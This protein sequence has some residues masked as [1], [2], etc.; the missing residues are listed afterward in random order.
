MSQVQQSHSTASCHASVGRRWHQPCFTIGSFDPDAIDTRNQRS[1]GCRS[2]TRCSPSGN[3]ND[4]SNGELA[5]EFLSDIVEVS[6]LQ[7]GSHQFSDSRTFLHER[8]ILADEVSADQFQVRWTLPWFRLA[9]RMK[10]FPSNVSVT[11]LNRRQ[12]DK[13]LSPDLNKVGND[14]LPVTHSF[15]HSLK[16]WENSQEHLRTQLFRNQVQHRIVDSTDKYF[17]FRRPELLESLIKDSIH[18]WRE[19]K[20]LAWTVFDQ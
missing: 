10:A 14:S 11:I 18:T 7:C 3:Q 4:E 1:C 2:N 13:D 16:I 19:Q 5:L 6:P 9:W 8:N 12:Y 17:A 20:G 15:I